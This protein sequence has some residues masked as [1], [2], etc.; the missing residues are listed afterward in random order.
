VAQSAVVAHGDHA[1]A[2]DAVAA[3]SVVRMHAGAGGVSR[4][5]GGVGLGRVRRAMARCGR[6]VL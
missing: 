6:T 2:V 1:A 3:D 4:G 5:A